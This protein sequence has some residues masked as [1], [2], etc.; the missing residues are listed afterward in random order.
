MTS[1]VTPLEIRTATLNKQSAT[2]WLESQQDAMVA[3]L[4]FLASQNS[5][6][7]SLPG[8]LAMADKLANWMELAPA[9]FQRIELPAHA[10]TE[11]GPMLRWDFQPQASRRVLLMIHY[12]TVFGPDHAFQSCELLSPTLL[13]GPGVADA[14]GGIVVL[15]YALQ[16]MIKFGLVT[17]LGWTVLL[18][19]DE[20]IGSHSSVAL[21]Q[22]LAPQ[23]DFGLLFEPALPSGALISQR[24]GSGNFSVT[25]HGQA[26]HAGRYFDRGRNAIA[27]L[28]RIVSALDGLNGQRA[29]T[30][31]NVG[32][33]SGGGPVNVVPDRATAKLN[34][35]APDAES[36]TWFEEQLKSIALQ[37][38]ERDGFS[39]EVT[40][41][42]TSPPKCINAAQ[43]ELMRA[44]ET[45]SA[46]LG[47]SP[48]QW[49]STGGVCD[50]N[51]LAA[52][53]LPNIDT[54]GPRGDGLHS[55]Q[56]CVQL[57]SIVEKAKLVVEIL[58]AFAE[59][60]LESLR[61]QK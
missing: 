16:A 40:G 26:A 58:F 7:Y 23:F 35:R 29:D 46:S 1:R 4:I 37:T 30:T 10:S 50:G 53:G 31:I 49:Q 27:E 47:L 32:F 5:G 54:L 24:K 39:C 21:M 44:V 42:F 36:A 61:R 41:S 2:H 34:V 33:V 59:G 60:K 18:N 3:D 19:P 14:K 28:S 13:R 48:V 12:D 11:T 52:A 51:K 55:D 45:C 22:E 57:D 56:E 9:E 38:S 15:R 8:L 20:E 17:D 6:S 43:L 25:V